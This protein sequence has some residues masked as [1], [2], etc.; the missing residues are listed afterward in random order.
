MKRIISIFLISLLLISTFPLFAF[1]ADGEYAITIDL[2][3]VNEESKAA[4][5]IVYTSDFGNN[6]STSGNGTELSVDEN[7]KIVKISKN[8]SDIIQNGFVLN[9][10]A[11]KK[12]LVKDVS[13]GD[14]A[15]FDSEHNSVVI[16]SQNYNPF[17]TTVLNYDGINTTRA[18]NKLIIYRN[19]ASSG[20]NT[21]GYE[22]V[23]N[24]EG[25]I[26]SV[27]G[28]NNAIPEGGFV[29]SGVG[30]KK[31]PIEAACKLGYTAV[32]D[33]AARTVTVS[34]TKENAVSGYEMR[35]K[36]LKK[37]LEES[38]HKY[39]DINH[40]AVNASLSKLEAYCNDMKTALASDEIQKYVF[41][42]SAFEKETSVCE[43]ALV[44]Y[45]PVETR[46]LWLRIP[47]KNDKETVEKTV[48]EI[49]EMGFNS[50]CIE[51]LFDSTT[52]MPVP[53]DSLFVHNPAFKG[54]D[55]L[56]LY[57]DE[58]HK[59]NIEVH[60]W[61]SCYRVGHDG[62]NNVQY[63]VAKKKPEWLNV[64]QNGSSVITNEYG[65][66]YFL[67]PALEEVREFLLESYRY[68]LENYAIDGFQLDYV[69]YPENTSVN[70]GY[71][72]FT[73]SEFKKLYG[74]DAPKSS[75]QKGWNEW[76]S[77]RAGYVTELVTEVG[78]LIKEIRPDVLF[79]CDVAPEYTTTKTKMCQDTEKWLKEGLVDVVY[80]MAYGTTDAVA[81][82]SGVTV[83]LAGDKIQ[84]VMG[85]R[86]NGAV[87]YREQVVK[88][89][90]CN[91]DGTAFFSYSQYVAGDYADFIKS[92][93]FA[94]EA[95]C[96]SYS[97]KSAIVAQLKHIAE[98]VDVRM[99]LAM[100]SVPQNVKD[101]GGKLSAL[102]D[103]LEGSTVK[104]Q[105]SE[106]EKA[107]ADGNA[108]IDEYK[109][110]DNYISEYLTSCLRI[111]EKTAKNSRDEEKAA[112]I[113]AH[114]SEDSSETENSEQN[115]DNSEKTTS[116]FEKVFQVLF[117]IIMSMGILGLPVY[118]WLNARKKRIAEANDDD[119][120][121]D[122]EIDEAS[123]EVSEEETETE[124]NAE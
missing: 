71:D 12:S 61:M 41:S 78:S 53:E 44:P 103:A 7:G 59:Y 6:T 19:K 16:V 117:V 118:Y 82:W 68:I 120:S 95:F 22:A 39:A 33:E 98:T 101:Y 81:K 62:S 89:R 13:V 64:D 109:D 121:D 92:T 106:I 60:A 18:E 66:A 97:A 91:A 93:V 83:E 114:P 29:I 55:M 49:Y 79:S 40:D 26:V 75:G 107:I 17:N 94:E 116:A 50:V 86:D 10:G 115:T 112:Y 35:I 21:W 73:L 52:I 76:C 113:A 96:P 65:N 54:V 119:D 102:A 51:I 57:I 38:V 69:R 88:A 45:I 30:N 15:Y 80:P 123:E 28:N 11:A 9:L 8:K 72:E 90:E 25:I 24:A 14:Y 56:E 104:A 87:I 20:T 111:V 27:G 42:S 108:L 46:A 5:V 77:L 63:S 105:F 31:Q 58:F 1:A 85:L 100:D 48:K 43:S 99:P 32:L 70:Y 74:Y 34:Y 3:G 4:T 67:N 122:Y 47:V 36:E 124:D 37:A 110:S 23:V 2:T 84:T